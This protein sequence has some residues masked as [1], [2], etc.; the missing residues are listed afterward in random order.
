ML[1]GPAYAACVDPACWYWNVA[2]LLDDSH[3]VGV[4]A[5]DGGFM[6][7]SSGGTLASSSECAGGCVTVTVINGKSVG[8]C[9]AE[10]ED[11]A[12]ECLG[13][14]LYRECVLGRWQRSAKV[15]EGGSRC[16]PLADTPLPRIQCGDACTPGTSRCAS[17]S[18]LERCGDDGVFEAAEECARGVCQSK[19]VQAY[20]AS[21]CLQD[22]SDCAFDGAS[23]AR[24]CSGEGQWSAE[25]ACDTGTTCRTSGGID[26]GCVECVGPNAPGGNAWGVADSRCDG[27]AVAACGDDNRWQPARPCDAGESCVELDSGPSTLAYCAVEP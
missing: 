4:C 14:P 6:A 2:G 16:Q 15:C 18:A 3:R 26:L 19:G 25:Q 21:E 7:C 12:Q 20:C 8:F 5:P 22:A 27:E 23:S 11:G 1:V 9:R 10:C 24:T 13:G 17:K